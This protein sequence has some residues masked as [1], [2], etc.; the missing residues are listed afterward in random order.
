MKSY[1]KWLY[2]SVSR[3]FS[4]SGHKYVGTVVSTVVVAVFMMVDDKLVAFGHHDFGGGLNRGSAGL[5]DWSA[6][7]GVELITYVSDQR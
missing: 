3:V 1:R 7:Q 2:P 5:C 4:L 6:S